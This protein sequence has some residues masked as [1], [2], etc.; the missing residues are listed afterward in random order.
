MNLITREEYNNALDIVEGYH[1]QVFDI[2]HIKKMRQHSKTRLFD[3]D[4]KNA[5]GTRL[6]NV[7]DDN[8]DLFLEDINFNFFIKLRRAGRKSWLEFQEIRG[9]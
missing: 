4:K 5:C 8:P 6:R 2:A 1:K 7:I 9:Y 3:W